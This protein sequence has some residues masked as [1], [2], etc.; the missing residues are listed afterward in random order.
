MVCLALRGALNVKE[1]RESECGGHDRRTGLLDRAVKC[2]KNESERLPL[3]EAEHIC[4]ISSFRPLE[5]S[6]GHAW[7]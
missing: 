4:M 2:R 3:S 6:V 7:A 5:S 1:D